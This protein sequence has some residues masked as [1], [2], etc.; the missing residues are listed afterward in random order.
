MG[1]RQG[2]EWMEKGRFCVTDTLNYTTS[3]KKRKGASAKDSCG[4]S[5]M[6]S[7]APSG[8][9]KL[10]NEVTLGGSWCL[11]ATVSR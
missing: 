5:Q 3:L 6:K 9:L 4:Q 2:V 8:V 1:E 11:S 10:T 7:T